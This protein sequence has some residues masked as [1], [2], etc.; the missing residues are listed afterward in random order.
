MEAP[1]LERRLTA[2]LA[3]DVRGGAI[4]KVLKR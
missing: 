2:I 1:S 3:T 4:A